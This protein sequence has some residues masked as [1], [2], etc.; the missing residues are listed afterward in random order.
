MHNSGS[1][2]ADGYPDSSKKVTVIP[3]LPEADNEPLKSDAIPV[4][5]CAD[6]SK[7]G[8]V[9]P[10]LTPE[11]LHLVQSISTFFYLPIIR[12]QLSFPSYD[13]ELITCL[14]YVDT[15]NN[16]SLKKMCQ[17]LSRDQSYSPKDL[18]YLILRNI[19]IPI[20]RLDI[21]T[22]LELPDIIFATDAYN[23]YI[24]SY[25]A[26]MCGS[27]QVYRCPYWLRQAQADLSYCVPNDVDKD[28]LKKSEVIMIRNRNILASCREF[29]GTQFICLDYGLYFFLFEWIRILLSNYR[30]SNCFFAKKI[31]VKPLYKSTALYIKSVCQYINGNADAS[32]LCSVP[33]LFSYADSLM[34]KD[35]ISHQFDFILA[36]EYSHIGMGCESTVE[37]EL[38]A[39]LYAIGWAKN[40]IGKSTFLNSDEEI[41]EDYY[42]IMSKNNS[43]RTIESIEIMFL[44]YDLFFYICDKLM[45][46]AH[47]GGI[48][49]PPIVDRI[50]QCQRHYSDKSHTNDFIEYSRSFVDCVKREYDQ[51]PAD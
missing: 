20:W 40:C 27:E 4:D 49:H 37:G 21:R 42:N 23:R 45:L 13:F 19:S 33:P 2:S 35:I 10:A 8:L 11:N 38:Q 41:T 14:D 9:F 15:L 43:D 44:F 36:H 47:D 29:R 48:C 26:K 17:A 46:N 12:N 18:M 51:F 24:Y 34:A 28:A 30:L 50:D 3:L 32:A 25:A 16:P 22:M 7:E 5:V 6:L 31:K 39:D 1:K